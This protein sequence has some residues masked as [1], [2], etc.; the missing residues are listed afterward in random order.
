MLPKKR[1]I[2]KCVPNSSPQNDTEIHDKVCFLVS[3][4]KYLP[5]QFPLGNI[6]Q[7]IL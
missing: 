3:I 2:L 5:S 1:I 7:Y 4:K 6:L